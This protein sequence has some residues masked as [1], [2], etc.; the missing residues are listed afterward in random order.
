ME[1][2][3]AMFKCRLCGEKYE[4]GGILNNK[5]AEEVAMSAIIGDQSDPL[6]IR[7]H[8]IHYCDDGSLGVADFI[9]IKREDE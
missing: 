4:D 8:D 7:L 6:E 5:D 3:I 1:M 2:Y 9:G